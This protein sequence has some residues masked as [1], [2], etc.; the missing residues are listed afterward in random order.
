[1]IHDAHRIRQA[2]LDMP[3]QEEDVPARR[4]LRVARQI[5]EAGQLEI[6]AVDYATWRAY[7]VGR[8]VSRRLSEE[9]YSRAQPI[10]DTMP[11]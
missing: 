2:P 6:P 11:R 8:N 10:V 7:G 3:V 4:F 9:A 1:M 5:A